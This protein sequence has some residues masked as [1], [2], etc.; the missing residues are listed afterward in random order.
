MVYIKTPKVNNNFGGRKA[1]KSHYCS[2]FHIANGNAEAQVY[3][4]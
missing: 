1:L 2:T 3:I 4:L